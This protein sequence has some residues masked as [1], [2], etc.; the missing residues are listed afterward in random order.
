MRN[1]FIKTLSLVLAFVMLMPTTFNAYQEMFT[2]HEYLVDSYYYVLENTVEPAGELAEFKELVSRLFAERQSINALG[3]ALVEEPLIPVNDA[4]FTTLREL[5][6]VM[7]EASEIQSRARGESIP[8][9]FISLFSEPSEYRDT[10]F[11]AFTSEEYFELIDLILDYTGIT[12]EEL[13]VA[14]MGYGVMTRS[15][16]VEPIT[17][18]ELFAEMGIVPFSPTV[19][20]MGQPV[21]FR[22]PGTIPFIQLG[23][24]GHPRNAL[25]R[26]TFSRSHGSVPRGST[27]YTHASPNTRIGIVDSQTFNPNLGIDVSFINLDSGIT[28]S[29]QQLPA[30]SANITNFSASPIMHS[31]HPGTRVF[32]RRGV[33]TGVA[34]IA[35]RAEANLRNPDTQR[36][37]RF[38]DMIGTTMAP[39]NLD[40][41]SAL[42]GVNNQVYG[43]LVGGCTISGWGAFSRARFYNPNP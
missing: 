7:A 25:G 6:D 23:S 14:V 27:I 28:V 5:N 20:P 2:E 24:L 10:F 1:L 17:D 22:A 11:I 18:E 12:R 15:Q 41:G 8:T 3:F 39:Q 16:I 40:S 29:R 33:V 35:Y 31:P 19:L 34:I 30:S 4:R 32:T 13:E 43:T 37:Y 38:R 26:Q 42:V 9:I 21:L 36:Q